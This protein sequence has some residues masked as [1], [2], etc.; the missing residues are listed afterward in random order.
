VNLPWSQHSLPTGLP[1]DGEVH[2]WRFGLNVSDLALRKFQEML[3]ETEIVRADRFRFPD[4]RRRFMAARG[5]LRSILAGYLSMNPRQL[6]FSY[7]PYGKPSLRSA[8]NE[9]QFNLSH[10]NDLMVAA[11]CRRG[12][13]GVDIEQEKPNFPAREIATRYFCE[14]EKNEIARADEK[15][16][17]RTF[18]QLW[19][20]KEAV[21]KATALGLSLELSKVEI[22]LD[23][24]SVLALEGPLSAVAAS[25]RLFPFCP[26]EGY[27]G[28]L[29]V[30]AEP[31]H[32]EYRSLC[33]A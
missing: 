21:T 7:G 27:V 28:T 16:G 24:L 1:A 22:G 23:P 10:C 6:T 9:I 32:L 33:L 2:V 15:T 12:F 3:S 31:V 29:A 25:W 11:V 17:L 19:T 26:A 18:F 14:R 20:A 5:A 8:S 4:L 13:V 30:A